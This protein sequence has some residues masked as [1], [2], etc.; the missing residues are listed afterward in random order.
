MFLLE[1]PIEHS[2]L[3]NKIIFL[4]EK[5]LKP[6]PNFL[7]LRVESLIP[8]INHYPLHKSSDFARN[9]PLGNDGKW[10]YPT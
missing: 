7:C 4:T 10:R 3:C 8:S 2:G 5:K 6:Q 9:Y 1:I